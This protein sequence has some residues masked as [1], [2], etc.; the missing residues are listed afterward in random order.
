MKNIP[1]Y[2]DRKNV[3]GTDGFCRD[4]DEWT[5]MF[6]FCSDWKNKED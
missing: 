4:S 2:A 6:D 5:Q 3:L 1:M